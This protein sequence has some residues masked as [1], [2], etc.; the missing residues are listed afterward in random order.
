MSRPKAIVRHGKRDT[1]VALLG[2][3]GAVDRNVEKYA[4]IYQ[5]KGYTTVQFTALAAVKGWGTKDGR[6]VDHLASTLDSVLINPSNRLVFHVFSMNGFIALTSLD[7]QFPELKAIEKCDGIF[8]DSCPACFSFSIENMQKHALVMNHVYDQLIK[9]SNFVLGN[10]Y[11][12]Y[13]KWETAR[14]GYQMI[15]DTMSIKAGLCTIEEANPF[16]YL[17]N[18]PH[19]P[20]ILTSIFS[21]NDIVCSADEINLFNEC[22]AKKSDKKRQIMA[23][24]LKDTAH[25]EHFRK[26]PKLYLE[27]MDEFLQKVEKLRNGGNSKL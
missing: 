3:A 21:D 6:N 12:V 9:N 13:K 1:I 17:L 18:H 2:W 14:F 11:K 24:R 27:K 5:K 19:L 22:A 8:M 7:S 16:F 23:T 10:F 4:G 20:P 26:Y 15:M 25:V